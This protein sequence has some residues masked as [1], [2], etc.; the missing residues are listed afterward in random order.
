MIIA[1]RKPFAE[2]KEMLAP[3]KKI[4]IM[5]CGSCVTVCLAGGQAEV[6]VLTSELKIADRQAGKTR[7]FITGTLTRQCDPEFIVP[8]AEQVKKE[9]PDAVISLACGVGVNYLAERLGAIPVFPGVD[10]KFYGAA[11][12][13][14]VWAEL[15]AGCGKCILHLTGGICP[16]ARCTKSLMNGPC[17]GTNKGK[18]EIS[19]DVDC[20]WY[21]IV[22]RMT[23]LGT[24][25]Q[26]SE[27]YAARD[28]STSFHGGVR[29][30]IH[31]SSRVAQERDRAEAVKKAGA[32]K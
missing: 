26:L 29:R 32:K 31:P 19:Q 14:G 1:E 30:Q 23:E 20:G 12:E 22:K 27:I 18:C 3:Y 24:L 4:M 9:K 2:I 7:E 10:T 28:W 15:C 11:L 8:L 5:G 6:D 16:I 17:G 21:L 13:H 25:D